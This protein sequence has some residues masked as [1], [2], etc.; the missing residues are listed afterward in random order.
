MIRITATAIYL[1]KLELRWRTGVGVELAL[2]WWW[3]LEFA[4]AL[5]LHAARSIEL[6]LAK[7]LIR[8]GCCKCQWLSARSWHWRN[9]G[10]HTR[11]W[12]SIA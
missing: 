9:S 10:W 7:D 4:R 12:H 6:A 1:Q 8:F 5:A 2:S 3:R 11:G